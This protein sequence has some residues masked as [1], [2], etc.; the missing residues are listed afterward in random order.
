MIGYIYV[1]VHDYFLNNNYTLIHEFFGLLYMIE[2]MTPPIVS[3]EEEPIPP[4]GIDTPLVDAEGYPRSDIDVYR[5]RELRHRLCVIQTDH[6]SLMKEI[7]GELVRFSALKMHGG[8][9]NIGSSPSDS[10]EKQARSATKPKPKFDKKTGK[11]VVMNWDGSIAGIPNGEQ[12]TFHDL[13][14]EAK[15]NSKTITDSITIETKALT[16]SNENLIADVKQKPLIPFAIINSV[17]PESPANLAGLREG[18]LITKFGSAT[19]SNNRNLQAIA[20]LVPQAA[21]GNQS[22]DVTVL[23][24]PKRNESNDKRDSE[25]VAD[26]VSIQIILRPRPWNGRGLLGCHILPYDHSQ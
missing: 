5:A 8:S 25:E 19:V 3:P 22:I 20:S 7:E 12:R 23:R 24:R 14:K 26:H 2:L 9:N 1:T 10:Y 15:S 6:K 13:G 21:G 16:I 4:M 17:S 18:D 11:W